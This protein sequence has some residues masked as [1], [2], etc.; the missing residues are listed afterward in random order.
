MNILVHDIERLRPDYLTPASEKGFNDLV[1]RLK[2]DYEPLKLTRGAHI[3]EL[4]LLLIQDILG[5]SPSGLQ[6][7]QI[8][9][10]RTVLIESEY[11]TAED[12]RC[13]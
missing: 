9:S 8:E 2:S 7:I 1:K 11:R 12:D 5:P 6:S 4:I 13:S 3:Y 10:I